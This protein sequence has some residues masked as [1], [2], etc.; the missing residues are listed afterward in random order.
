MD[1]MEGIREKRKGGRGERIEEV[2]KKKKV[3]AIEEERE[4]NWDG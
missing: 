2:Q 4:R 1:V 3:D